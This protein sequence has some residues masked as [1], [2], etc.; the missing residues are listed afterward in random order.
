MAI[1]PTPGAMFGNRV[2]ELRQKRG[3]TQVDLSQRLDLPQSRISEIESGLR[4]PNLVT[5]LRLAV[6]LEC[7]PSALI[8][9][10]DGPD[11]RAILAE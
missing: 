10:F 2:R 6:A 9:V 11:L 7:K 3:L 1:K 5:I 4:A 8:S